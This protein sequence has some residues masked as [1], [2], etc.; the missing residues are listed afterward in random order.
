MKFLLLIIVIFLLANSCFAST[1][2]AKEKTGIGILGRIFVQSEIKK[3]KTGTRSWTEPEIIEMFS[4]KDTE[5]MVKGLYESFKNVVVTPPNPDEYTEYT[6]ENAEEALERTELVG[7][8]AHNMFLSF[9]ED[10]VVKYGKLVA[11]IRD[12]LYFDT[13]HIPLA[14]KYDN[15]RDVYWYMVHTKGVKA[16]EEEYLRLFGVVEKNLHE[17]QS[18]SE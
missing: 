9:T 2:S 10:D 13:Q 1:A 4:K 6:I 17:K 8:L 5:T 12:I 16:I 7:R 18:S 14:I 11:L 15:S 3:I